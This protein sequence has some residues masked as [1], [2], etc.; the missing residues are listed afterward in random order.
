M[1]RL[2]SFPHNNSKIKVIYVYVILL[3]FFNL[4]IVNL[5]AVIGNFQFKVF[6]NILAI[7]ILNLLAFIG[8][9]QVK[10]NF[11][12]ILADFVKTH[13][14]QHIFDQAFI[15]NFQLKVNFEDRVLNPYLKI[16]ILNLRF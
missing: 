13:A 8:N 4:R 10:D 11:I 16:F 9:F 14:N 2:Q 15:S 7:N 6:I 5:L 3:E 12:N 1:N